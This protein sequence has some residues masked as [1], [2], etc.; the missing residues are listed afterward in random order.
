M[1]KKEKKE[2]KE[3]LALLVE[4]MH[5]GFSKQ[6]EQNQAILGLVQRGDMALDSQLVAL[7][8]KINDKLQKQAAIQSALV[9]K[10]KEQEEEL[11]QI[12]DTQNEVLQSLS[13][14]LK[15]VYDKLD[16]VSER[17]S[18]LRRRVQFLEAKK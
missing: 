15:D 17:N 2:K 18:A 8:D 7:L 16:Q 11:G 6:M 12:L 3:K 14:Q 1:E 4:K 9:A 10:A 5:R 13:Q